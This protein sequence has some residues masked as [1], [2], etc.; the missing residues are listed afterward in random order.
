MM[1]S[2]I[3]AFLVSIKLKRQNKLIKKYE[4]IKRHTEYGMK[5]HL[6]WLTAN[7]N[8]VN[9]TFVYILIKYN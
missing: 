4:N 6:G 2:T 1:L 8:C 9:R 7:M 3:Q 5:I